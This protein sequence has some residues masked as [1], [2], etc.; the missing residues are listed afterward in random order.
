MARI[1]G[2]TVPKWVRVY[3]DGYDISGYSR[4]IGPLR[5]VYEEADLTVQMAD[6]VM[7]ALPN[8]PSISVGTLNGVFDN[9]AT[10]GLHA[11]A[12][13][14][15]SSRIITVPIGI[16]AVPQNGDTCFNGQFV[17]LGYTG[18]PVGPSV[19]ANVPFG[20]WD[21]ANELNYDQAWGQM[22]HVKA[23]RTGANGTAAFT[24]DGGAATTAGGYLVYHIFA[25]AGGDGTATISI[26]DSADDSAYSAL[27]G[28]TSGSL[29]CRS[30]QKGIV[31]L[32][33]GATVRQY[34]RWQLALG[35]ATT[36]TFAIAFVRGI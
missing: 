8:L 29:D 23:A 6:A 14:V 24:V 3:M 12:S 26:D 16:Q 2:R 19:Y 31:Q 35:Q 33:V 15:P 28:A 27:S 18:E 36:V 13:P 7:G 32:A 1:L 22:V 34:L 17:Q 10:S 9:T 21:V 11:L 20:E 25:G 4:T 30:V 5:H